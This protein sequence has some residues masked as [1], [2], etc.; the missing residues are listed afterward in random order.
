MIE[1]R[2]IPVSLKEDDDERI[3]SI[4]F[5]KRKPHILLRSV[6]DINPEEEIF[7]TLH[8]EEPVK[9]KDGDYEFIFPMSVNNE[10]SISTSGKLSDAVYYH[11]KD[12]EVNI[13]INLAPGFEIGDVKS[14]THSLVI[15]KKSKIRQKIQLTKDAK[16][17]HRDFIL[18]YSAKEKQHQGSNISPL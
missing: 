6:T 12:R 1:D 10:V 4:I 2:I 18:K 15:Q 8:Y 13:F 5:E 11:P 3:K 17:L 9:Y 14:P 16:L 7:I